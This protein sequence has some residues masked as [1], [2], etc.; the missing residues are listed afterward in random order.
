MN[1]SG[2]MVQYYVACK[3]ELWF[4]GHR[5]S[6]NKFDENILVGRQIHKHSYGCM[7]RNVLLDDCM[8]LDV[9]TKGD[10]GVRIFEVKKSSRLLDPA[11][12]QTYFYL[13]YLKHHKDISAD[14]IL[15]IPREKKEEILRLSPEIEEKIEEIVG[16]IPNVLSL[17]SPPP[18]KKKPYCRRCSYFDFCS[19]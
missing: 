9:V 14:A 12:M 8:S 7:R 3:R 18:A 6:L 11:R 17:P 16:D 2:V 10:G 4:F 19:I 5:V 13:W 15:K 1:V